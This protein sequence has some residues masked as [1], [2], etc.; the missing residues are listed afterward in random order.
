MIHRLSYWSRIIASIIVLCFASIANSQELGSAPDFAYKNWTYDNLVIPY[1]E[2]VVHGDD[3]ESEHALVIYLHG[4]PKRG[5][6]NI[7]HMA[8]TGIGIIANYL[9]RQQVKAIMIVPQC[10]TNLTWGTPTNQMLFELIEYYKNNHNVNAKRI[11]LLGGSMGGTGTWQMTAE[12]PELFAAVMPVAGN[13]TGIKV[14]NVCKTPIFAV[15][16][17]NDN[18]I[19]IEPASEL[20]NHLKNMDCD[21]MIDIEQ[22]WTHIET[23]T[24]SYT[25]TRL[26]WLFKHKRK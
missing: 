3:L 23:C 2:A 26:D 13:P 14:Q 4:G 1:R 19:P 11:Y 7:A 25:D 8:E 21:V 17:L 20:I 12:Y 22:T 6:D 24:N 9:E 16:G 18:L 10:P 15:M 5:N